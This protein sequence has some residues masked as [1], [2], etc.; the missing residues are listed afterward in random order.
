MHLLVSEQYINYLMHGATTKVII[1]LVKNVIPF[2]KIC[3]HFT[4]ISFI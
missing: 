1:L 4:I 2:V 3:L